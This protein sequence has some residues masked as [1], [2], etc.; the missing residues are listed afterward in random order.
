M[1]TPSGT[2]G[3]DIEDGVTTLARIMKVTRK[4][5][6]ISR[7][8]DHDEDIIIVEESTPATDTLTLDPEEDEDAPI[9]ATNVL[10]IV[11]G[12]NAADNETV[13]IDGK[14]YTFQTTLTNVDGHVKIGADAA[15]SLGNLKAA[16]NLSAGAGT[17]YAAATTLHPTVTAG[18]IDATAPIPAEAT[19]VST[20]DFDATFSNLNN[21]EVAFDGDHH[22]NF[23]GQPTTQDCKHGMWVGAT[24]SSPKRIAYVL[25]WPTQPFGEWQSYGDPIANVFGAEP[26]MSAESG[27]RQMLADGF[28]L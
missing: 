3:D 6:T 24:F 27:R 16:I 2:V 1:R 17:K 9:A 22:A 15:T 25:V 7:F 19:L 12:Q 11:S 21:E 26:Y 20:G 4:D 18:V 23:V 5:G 13:V 14:T 28:D 8:T 10:T